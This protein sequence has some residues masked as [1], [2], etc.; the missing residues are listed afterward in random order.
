[1][2]GHQFFLAERAVYLI[3]F[4]V[5]IDLQQGR[6]SF[7]I[8]SIHANVPTA[9]VV[10]VDTH[11]DM[12]MCTPQYMETFKLELYYL[13]EDI[14]KDHP[15]RVHTIFW[16]NTRQNNPIGTLGNLQKAIVTVAKTI[17]TLLE[18][19]SEQ[20]VPFCN[21]VLRKNN[22]QLAIQSGN[23]TTPLLVVQWSTL[24]EVG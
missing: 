22:K 10:L 8:K 11:V 13:L 12:P 6:L 5:Q 17:P 24:L 21:D 19:I 4:D 1:M 16:M 20:F 14:Q 2:V 3:L 15:V 7:W 18:H 23:S 9:D